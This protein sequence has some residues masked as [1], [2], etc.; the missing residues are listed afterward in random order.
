M[1]EWKEN[2]RRLLTE[3]LLLRPFVEAD[4]DE[5]T[6]ICNNVK[7][8]R[9]TTLPHPYTTECALSWIGK[10]EAQAEAGTHYVW[11][12]TDRVSGGLYG[13]VSL[14][15]S[16]ENQ[17]AELGY[18]MAEEVWGRG[19]AT[20]AARAALYFA[21]AVKAFHRVYA[22]HYGSNPAS[23]RVMQKCGMTCEGRLREH[24]RKADGYEDLVEY[25]ILKAEFAEAR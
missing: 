18:W 5:V 15:C 12:V 6:R 9:G 22:R 19:Y 4:A 14:T 23:G 17:N 10:Q 11:A 3:R 21:F 1:I 24:R 20:E 7:V 16:C 2:E 25:G 13:C 8:A